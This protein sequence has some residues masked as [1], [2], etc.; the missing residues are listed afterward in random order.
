MRWV[1]DYSEPCVWAILAFGT[2]ALVASFLPFGGEFWTGVA[3]SLVFLGV[4]STWRIRTLGTA[5][6]LLES[7]DDLHNENNR[8]MRRVS[9]LQT[10]GAELR[11]TIASQE[12]ANEE[13]RKTTEDLQGILGIVGD[14]VGDIDAVLTTLRD[15]YHK[16]R[17]ENIK[18]E[19]NNLL[20]FFDVVD[21]NNDGTLDSEE[22]ARF[23]S[24]AE[25]VYGT[26]LESLDRDRD[27]R[28]SLQEFILELPNDQEF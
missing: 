5:Y 28:V 4:L 22:M 12:A 21:R 11:E 18:H 23:R 25:K 17:S 14:R 15:L 6:A 2:V 3:A 13:L 9:E 7:V 1:V 10:L 24:F 16:Y 8:L 19:R 27:G 26:Q 20:S